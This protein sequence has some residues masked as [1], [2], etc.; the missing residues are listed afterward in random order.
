MITNTQCR[1]LPVGQLFRTDA[2]KAGYK[3]ELHVLQERLEGAKLDL[4]AFW[5]NRH[6]DEVIAQDAN[7]I[8]TFDDLQ[9]KAD[10]ALE[11]FA[12]DVKPIKSVFVTWAQGSNM[13]YRSEV[14]FMKRKTYFKCQKKQMQP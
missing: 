13:I 6:D 14:P 7:I 3:S 9:S 2:M 12:K 10:N 4:E 1:N 8:T 5:A 11:L